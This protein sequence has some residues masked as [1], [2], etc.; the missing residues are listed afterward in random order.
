MA[1][2]EIIVVT[3]IG[4][5]HLFPCI[6]L[7][8]HISSRN[9]NS[10]LVLPS[11]LSSSVPSSFLHHPH[12]AT[13]LISSISGGPPMPGSDATR[14]Q[15]QLDLEAHLT[16]RLTGPDSARPLCA[17]IDFQMG[18]TKHVFWKFDIPVI[19]FFTFGACAAAMEWGAWKADAGK[20][21]PGDFRTIPGLPEE[22]R[23]THSD[24]KGRPRG[25]PPPEKSG[26]VRP[27]GGGGGGPKPGS[28]PPW[29][30][31]I[32][33]SIG[34][35]FNTCDDI[36]R[37]FIDYMINQMEMPV[38][39]VGPLLP[40][41]YWQSSDSLIR[42]RE[43]RQPKRQ[44]NYTEDELIHWLDSKPRGSVLYVAFGSE[45]G[46]AM[47]EYPQLAGALEDAM[48]PFIWVIQPGSG[49][50]KG[51]PGPNESG[52]NEGYFPHGLDGKVGE[53]GLIIRGWAPQL[54]ILSHPSTGGF[55]SHCGWN[56]TVEA[57]GRGVPF[58]AWPIRGDQ[59]YNAKLVVDHLKVGYMASAGDS[60]EMIRKV[61]ILVGIEKLMGDEEVRK[62]AIALCAKFK[63]GFPASSEAALDAFSV[64]LSQ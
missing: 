15:I 12:L 5:G 37:P 28:Q 1:R 23:V 30:P 54:L 40:D 53:R 8:K 63:S 7:C 4:S 27:P 47:D 32:E 11:N 18:W 16:S 20:L 14:Q 46:P 29:V 26:P 64:F 55:L 43:I 35:M 60:S 19:S 10:T 3:S 42:D 50:S 9:Y 21:N 59:I 31:L 57:I 22:M 52:D 13:V 34:L 49:L 44:T 61:V 58:L 38:W 33:G 25:P 56:S 2:G 45:T 51:G 17:V 6:E 62:R 39:G 24:I 36:E 48:C 41:Q